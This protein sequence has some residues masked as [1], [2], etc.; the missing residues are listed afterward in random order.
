MPS[1]VGETGCGNLI[2]C[3]LATYRASKGRE[4]LNDIYSP[5]E[6]ERLS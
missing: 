1:A 2:L 4:G 3:L 5:S 6:E